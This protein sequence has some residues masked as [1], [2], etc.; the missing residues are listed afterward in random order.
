M[1]WFILCGDG[2]YNSITGTANFG[3]Y[4]IPIIAVCVSCIMAGWL[5]L[6]LR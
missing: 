2:S 5:Y 4:V 3:D 1:N 6:K